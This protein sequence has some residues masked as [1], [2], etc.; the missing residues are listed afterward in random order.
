M[1]RFCIK[2]IECGPEKHPPIRSK[3]VGKNKAKTGIESVGLE[4]SLVT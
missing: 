4:R 2:K 1:M 3:L